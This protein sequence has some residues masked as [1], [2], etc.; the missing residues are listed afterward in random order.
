M[1]VCVCVCVCVCI[2]REEGEEPKC[3]SLFDPKFSAGC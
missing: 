1:C 3:V 2:I